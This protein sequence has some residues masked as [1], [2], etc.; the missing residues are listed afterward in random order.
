M[1][2]IVDY[3]KMLDYKKIFIICLYLALN[4]ICFIYLNN[5]ISVIS[6]NNEDV[7][8]NDN[9]IIS[10]ISDED[11]KFIFVD[12][13]GAIKSP[14]V[15]KLHVGSR[16]IDAINIAGGLVKDSNTLHMNLS[17]VLKDSDIVKVYTNKEIEKAQKEDKIDVIEPCVC[18]E[19][20]C[21][22][23]I[24]SE[25]DK[26]KI[27]INTASVE[28]LDTL[29]GIGES[30]AKAIFEYRKSNGDFLKIEDIMNVNGISES[31]FEKIKDYITV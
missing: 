4:I 9:I 17:G 7:V 5:K 14:G 29:N 22:N 25:K 1:E 24:S 23:N 20:I 12:V 10:T 3:I 2:F 13:K 31:I 8:L 15:Y 6:N 21:D 19:V 26:S 11:E 30:K 18:E 16:V 28:E 27:N